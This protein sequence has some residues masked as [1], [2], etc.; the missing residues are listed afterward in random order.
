MFGFGL[1]FWL[2]LVLWYG[3]GYGQN[4]SRVTVG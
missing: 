3:L 4:I 2:G 1:W